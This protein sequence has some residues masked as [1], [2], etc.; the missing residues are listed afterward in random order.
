[1]SAVTQNKT[2]R[3]PADALKSSGL[4]LEGI[5]DLS[6]LLD[7]SKRPGVKGEAANLSLDLIDEDTEQPRQTFPEE[8][9]AE[10]TLSIESHGVKVPIS[11]YPHPE[12]EGRFMLNDGARRTRASIRAGKE[13]IPAVIGEKFTRI[14][15]IIVNKVREDTPPMDK[16][17]LFQKLM[18][19][20][21]WSQKDLS[22]KSGLSEAYVS[23]HMTLLKLPAPVAEVFDSGRCTDV[24]LINEVSKAYKKKP[25]AVKGWL[26]DG[27]QEIT[28]GSVKLLRD[29]LDEKKGPADDQDGAG[30]EPSDSAPSSGKTPKETSSKEPDPEKIKKAIILGMYKKRAVRLLTNKRWSAEG[31]AWVKYEDN[32]EE[33]E[34]ELGD[35]KLNRL[36]EGA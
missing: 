5:G 8:E 22:Q 10:L 34:I 19:E 24:T 25:E 17:R 11:V 32:G 36:I 13:T 3:K 16:A 15:Q 18:Q 2:T 21:G 31:F 28:R 20:N 4:G 14:E 27:E 26:E 30:G 29:F 33:I 23:Q 7:P 9:M 6:S 35:L 1:M 12:V